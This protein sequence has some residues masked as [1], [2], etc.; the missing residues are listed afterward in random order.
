MSLIES[1][2]SVLTEHKMYQVWNA[3]ISPNDKYYHLH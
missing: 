3:F 2:T 1:P